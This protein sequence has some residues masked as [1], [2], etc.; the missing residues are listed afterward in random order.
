MATDEVGAG[1]PWVDAIAASFPR[2]SFVEFHT[3]ELPAINARH[4]ALVIDDLAGVPPLAFELTDGATYTWRATSAGVEAFS[5]DA[6]AATL[7][8]L[9]ETTFSAFVNGLLTASGAVRTNRARLLRGTLQSW[10]RWE[11][12]IQTLLTGSPIY[13]EAV[14]DVL[15]DRDGQPLDLHR[16]FAADDDRDAMR[17]FLDVAGYLHIRGVYNAVEIGAW[18]A[19]VE[20]VR[21]MS[22]PGDPFSW[23]SLNS[24][25][26]EIVTRINY[27]GRYSR[28]LQELCF[29]PRVT[30]YARLAGPKLRVCDDRLDGPMVF[31]KHSDVVK[32]DGDLGWHVDDGIGGHPVM[33]PLIQ[34]GIQLDRANA[35]NGQLMV[36]AGSHRYTKH[37]IEWGQEG[38]LPLVKLDTEPGD[39]TLHYG[40]IM[41]STPPPTGANAGRRVL[42]YK[43]AEAKTFGWIPAGCHYNDALFLAD[44]TGKVSSRAA[45]H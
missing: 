25:G 3:F 2:H 22:S 38:D 10:R 15:V 17:H 26:T 29:E 20:K 4:G 37:W 44:A 40:D 43:F 28:V 30:E 33:C 16:A 18:I 45:T 36:L 14:R 6:D 9:D 19:E 8:A 11:P 42:Y 27:L 12:A 5:G 34:A 21:G 41:H 13:T 1:L 24:S 35:A 31:I 7:V 32:G 23:W 39:L